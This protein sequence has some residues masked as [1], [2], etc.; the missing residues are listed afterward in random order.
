M[1]QRVSIND[2]LVKA[3]FAQRTDDYDSSEVDAYFSQSTSQT[4]Q[5]RV[6]PELSDSGSDIDGFY[7]EN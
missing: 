5:Y 4:P 1:L 2:E 7:V 3:G 6:L